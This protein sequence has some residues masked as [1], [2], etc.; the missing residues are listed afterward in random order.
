MSTTQGWKKR[1]AYEPDI[2]IVVAL[3]DGR[4]TGGPHSVGIYTSE[5]VD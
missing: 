1:D 2:T 5:G 4:Q 3:F